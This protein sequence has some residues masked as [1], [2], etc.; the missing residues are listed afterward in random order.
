MQD[1][2][3]TSGNTSSG[4]LA[5]DAQLPTGTYFI[6]QSGA[7]LMADTVGTLPADVTLNGGVYMAGSATLPAGLSVHPTTGVI[8]TDGTTYYPNTINN[9]GVLCA[10]AE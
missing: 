8:L 1:A 7:V 10:A 6:D 3:S 2:Q 4:L 5:T 9:V